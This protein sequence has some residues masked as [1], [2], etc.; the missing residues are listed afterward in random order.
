MLV[1]FPATWAGEGGKAGRQAQWKA[2]EDFV[3]AGKAKAIGAVHSSL[4]HVG[5]VSRRPFRHTGTLGNSIS[6]HEILGEIQKRRDS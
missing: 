2:M 4:A 6:R 1:H 3:K 5:R